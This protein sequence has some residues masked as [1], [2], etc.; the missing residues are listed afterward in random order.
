MD[1][2]W[3]AQFWAGV[4]AFAI[5]V[6]VTLD[7]YDLGVGILFGTTAKEQHRI[8]MMNAIA[9]YWDG[10][11]TWLV[12]VGAS[13]FAAFP[14]VY[15]I[16]L[17]ALLPAGRADAARAD[18]PWRRLRVP[19][20]QH[21]HAARVGSRLFPRLADRGPHAGCGDRHD[22]AGAAGGRWALC[23]RPVRMAHTILPA[24]RRRARFGIRLAGRSLAGAEDRRR[25]PRLG[26]SQA[27][28]VAPGRHCGARCV[29]CIR[30]LYSPARA[31]SL[32]RGRRGSCCCPGSVRR[33]SSA[34]GSER[35]GGAMACRSRWRSSSLPAPS[36]HSA[37]ASGRT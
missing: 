7:G 37:P 3:L 10:N 34:C 12:L 14:M 28:L 29:I 24:L 8:T 26:L 17:P 21:A 20:P 25:P 33:L 27:R 13:L 6:Y 18:L 23:R 35:D 9:P 36:R 19:P 4:I 15:A 31:R 30:A 1:P 22:G 16:F 2:V 5:L 32:A 11:E